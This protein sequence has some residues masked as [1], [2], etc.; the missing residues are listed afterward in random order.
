MASEP[1]PVPPP[2]PEQVT[3]G[4]TDGLLLEGRLHP[5]TLLFSVWH[6]VR[7][8]LIPLIVIVFFGRKRAEDLYFLFAIVFL[9]L[10]ISFAIVRYF[11]FTYRIQNGELITHHGV[12]GKT[13]RIIPLSR[14]QDIRVEQSVLHRLFRM[15]D[16]H[17]ETAGGKE[18]EASLSVL[19]LAEAERL[20]AAVFDVKRIASAATEA[21]P[22]REIIR[23]LSV[24]ELVFAGL[25]SNQM[26]SAIAVLLVVWNFLDDFISRE[27]YERW[28]LRTTQAATEWVT[29]VGHK[30]WIGFLLL[31]GAVILVGMVFSIVGSVVMFYGFT[32][33]R[34]GEDLHRSYGLFTRRWSSLP[35]RRIQVLKVEE[36]IL[37]RLFGLATLRADTA[38]STGQEHHQNRGGRDMLLPIVPR[39]ELESLLPN[40]FPDLDNG[41]DWRQVARVAI[42]RGTLKGSVACAILAGISY[43]AQREWLALWPLL[44]VPIVFLLNVMSFR[45][46]GYVH[47]A[48]YFRTRRG[49]LRRSTH[50]VPIR[51]AQVVLVR[52]T[53]FDRRFNV[54]SVLVDTAGKAHT[55]GLPRIGNVPHPEALELARALARQAAE[56]R[57]RI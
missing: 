32:L 26:A 31:A 38:A 8:I 24:R 3:P 51:N 12:L 54:A 10:P 34:S 18:P 41:G 57:F 48:K 53:P 45:Y 6:T 39:R 19:S 42:R 49:W 47:G 46:L 30:A 28:V 44:L 9:A 16:V 7:G 27:A 2:I 23:K 29:H 1:P 20:R 22:S 11:T 5:L 17:V 13:Q 56:T 35:R 37:R 4:F 55:G 21:P 52:Q 15:A 25:T 36:T 14:V 50:I 40:F 33:A 43:W